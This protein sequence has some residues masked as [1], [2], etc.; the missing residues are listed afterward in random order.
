MVGRRATEY[1][2]PVLIHDKIESGSVVKAEHG[3]NN[4]TI[5]VL[6]FSERLRNLQIDLYF[7]YKWIANEY[8]WRLQ[9]V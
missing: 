2:N 4:F 1:F 5:I 9:Y 8:A 3:A 7:V 6:P